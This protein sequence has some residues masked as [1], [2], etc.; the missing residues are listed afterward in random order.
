M[1]IEWRQT[2]I[3]YLIGFTCGV[4]SGILLALGFVSHWDNRGWRSK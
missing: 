1:T 3:F 2:M 4:A